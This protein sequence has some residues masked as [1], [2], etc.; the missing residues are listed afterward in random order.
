MPLLSLWGSNPSAVTQ[1]TV[2][3]VVATAGDGKLRDDSACSS[4][5]RQYLAQVSSEL[6]AA[7]AEHCLTSAFSKSGLALQD[8]ANE[9]GR[10]LDYQVENGRYQ[11]TAGSIGFDGIWHGPEGKDLVVEVKTT[12]AYRIPLDRIAA[13]RDKLRD[14]GRVGRDASILIVVGREDTGELEAQVRGSRHAWDMRL[15]SVDGLLTLVKLT[16][17][18]EAGVTGAKIRSVLVPMEYT[19]LDG[20]VDVMFTAAK[21]VEATAES[22]NPE[23]GGAG[24]SDDAPSGWEF[25]DPALLQAKRD[26]ILSALGARDGRKLIKRSRALYWDASHSYRVA[27]S[28]SK[29]YTKKGQT[30]YWY[31]YHP[32]WDSF[33]GGGEIGSIVLG[34]VDLDIAFVLSL[35][36]M[37]AHLDEFS[38]STKKDGAG[39]YWHL[40]ILEPKPGHFALQLPKSGGQ[41]PLDPFHLVVANAATAAES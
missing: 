12:D 36:I 26:N 8:V 37:R 29:R 6:L 18:T 35:E 13:Y 39:H 17:S 15:I 41:L 16:E 20:L 19:R 38:T 30:P 1:L 3:Q 11:G 10:R 4:E 33:L 2:E 34:C 9:L 32:G 22:A 40:K 24:E 14:A 23:P 31:A 25:T 7:Y 5:L 28:I 21:D 27:C